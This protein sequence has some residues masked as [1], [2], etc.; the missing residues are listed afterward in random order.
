MVSD[1]EFFL[2]QV[3]N[4]KSFEHINELLVSYDMSGISSVNEEL[5]EKEREVVIK[6]RFPKMLCQDFERMDEMEGL[7]SKDH[8]RKVLEYGGEKKL[9]HQLI[10]GCL[11]LIEFI[12]TIFIHKINSLK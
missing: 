1:W 4:N 11:M 9:Y 10:T 6:R 12:D 5:V 7:L 2:T 3:F 8:V